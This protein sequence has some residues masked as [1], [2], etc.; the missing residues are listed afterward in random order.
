MDLS[1]AFDCIPH[2]LLIAKVSGYELNGNALKYIHTYL[3]NRKQCVCVNNVCSDFKGIILG[4]PQGSIIGPIHSYVIFSF[5]SE[6]RLYIIVLMIL[7]YH[8]LQDLLRC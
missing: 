3:K 1:K 8:H 4:V 2:D 7:H 6:K 5:A